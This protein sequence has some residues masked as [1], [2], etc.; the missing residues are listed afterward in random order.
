MPQL[1]QHIDAIARQKQRGVL[2]LNFRSPTARDDDP[3]ACNFDWENAPIRQ[4]VCLWLTQH[5]IPWCECGEVAS[6][7]CMTSYQGQ[8]YVDVPFD[9]DNP[10]YRQVR[11]YLENP[12]GSMRFPTVI[13]WYLPLEVAMKNAHHDAPGFWEKWAE[14]F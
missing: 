7:N 11:D 4:Q 5:E 3:F 13:F 12:D 10:V 6:E 1:L 2:F 14:T 9:E 8:I